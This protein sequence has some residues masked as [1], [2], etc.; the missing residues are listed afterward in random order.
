MNILRKMHPLILLL[1]TLLKL[2]SSSKLQMGTT[3]LLPYR[4]TSLQDNS[5]LG[6]ET[7][8][9]GFKYPLDS[10]PNAYAI[11]LAGIEANSLELNKLKIDL[12]ISSID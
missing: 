2:S 12:I 5:V 9:I 4:E 6:D 3:Q 1:A 8:Y 11:G 7:F 10:T